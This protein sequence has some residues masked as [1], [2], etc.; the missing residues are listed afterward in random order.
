MNH[1]PGTAAGN[2]GDFDSEPAAALLEQ[3]K[4]QSRVQFAP[5]TPALFAFRAVAVLVAFGALWLSVRGQDPYSGP[6]G[7]AIAF[8]VAILAINSGASAWVIKRAGD[9][10][11]A[12][13][14]RAG[15]A[16]DG[17]RLVAL[18]AAYVVTASLYHAG[19]SQPV[20]GLYPANAPLLLAVLVAAAAAA[21]HRWLLPGACLAMA[22]VAVAAGFGG[23]VDAWLIMG[24]GVCAVMLGTAAFTARAQR[25]SVVRPRPTANSTR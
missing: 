10:V 2:G 4:A 7:W 20:W 6:S 23:P 19:A 15:L 25:R 24:I 12:A 22:I 21:R 1:P 18:L 8:G 9:G 13:A 5:G 3:T 11:S 16:W 17:V 14:K